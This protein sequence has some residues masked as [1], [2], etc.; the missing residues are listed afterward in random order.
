M[1]SWNEMTAH[2]IPSESCAAGANPLLYLNAYT[3]QS[4]N[5]SVPS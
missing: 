2:A 3:N 4:A 5:E 1:K